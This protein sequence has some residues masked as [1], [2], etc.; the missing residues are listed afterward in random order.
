MIKHPASLRT[1]LPQE[2]SEHTFS[3]QIPSLLPTFCRF[4]S[5]LVDLVAV[6][7]HQAESKHIQKH[8]KKN[9]RLIAKD[10]RLIGENRRFKFVFFLPTL[11]SFQQLM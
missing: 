9:R 3:R 1:R 4:E 7:P 8:F 11:L 5:K 10:R 6:Q 2:S